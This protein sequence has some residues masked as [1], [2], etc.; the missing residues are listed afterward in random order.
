[1]SVLARYNSANINQLMERLQKNTIGMDDYFDRVF[2]VEAQSYPPYN[3]VQVNEDESLLEM[4]LAGFTDQEVKVYTEK[5]NLV[6]EGKKAQADDRE[7]VHRG[8]AQRSFTRTWSIS[9]DTE[10]SGVT[11]D[12]GLL[13][14]TLTRVVPE[15]RKK[16]FFLGGE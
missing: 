15:A 3:L 10:V 8:M 13:V 14:V 9:E 1:M 5:G 7:Y 12:N 16:R 2:G 11:F 6:V 4:A